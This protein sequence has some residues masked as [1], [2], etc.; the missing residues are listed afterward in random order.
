M[1]T[2]IFFSVGCYL[3]QIY[4]VRFLPFHISFTELSND[5]VDCSQVEAA[6]D[7]YVADEL[8]S[9]GYGTHRL[10]LKRFDNGDVGC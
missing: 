3:M 9:I 10:S 6:I 2:L 4:C 8:W 5:F 1:V 7:I